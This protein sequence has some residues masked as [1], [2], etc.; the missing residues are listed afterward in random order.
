MSQLY[1]ANFNVSSF[2]KFKNNEFNRQ[3]E[4]LCYNQH[5]DSDN[6]KKLKFIT[7]NYI[8]LIDAKEKLNFF[9]IGI[10]DQLFVPSDSVDTYSDLLN[11]KTGQVLTNCNVRNSFGALPLSTMPYRGQLQHGDI[12]IEDSIRNNIEV[13]KNSILPR[14]IEFQKRSFAIF[15]EYNQIDTPQ[16]I[17]SVETPQIGFCLGR[18]GSPTRFSDKFDEKMYSSSGTNYVPFYD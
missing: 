4:D 6:K 3:N 11:G 18:N 16:A 17:K 15:N 14:D 12:R 5:R 2:N 8:D 7:T 13:K 9:G 1:P 10:K